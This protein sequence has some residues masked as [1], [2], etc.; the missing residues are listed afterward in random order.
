M[1]PSSKSASDLKK[2]SWLLLRW[3]IPIISLS[4]IKQK[5]NNFPNNQFAPPT[6]LQM[7]HSLL[8]VECYLPFFAFT[9]GPGTSTCLKSNVECEN[10][11]V[12]EEL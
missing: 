11:A 10:R 6:I 3:S 12:N 2:Q 1:E 7:C 4:K 9:F 8:F 5:G